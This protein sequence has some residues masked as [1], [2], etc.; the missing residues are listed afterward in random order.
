MEI[1]SDDASPGHFSRIHFY[2]SGRRR[3]RPRRASVASPGDSRASFQ[4]RALR[5]PAPWELSSRLSVASAEDLIWQQRIP[6][7]ETWGRE[8]RN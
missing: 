5:R 4:S 8:I 6:G 2:Y 3:R 1:Y 7:N